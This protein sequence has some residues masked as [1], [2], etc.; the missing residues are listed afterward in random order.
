[1]I[2]AIRP[3]T[4]PAEITL[5]S[6]AADG[7]ANSTA[8]TAIRNVRRPVILPSSSHSFAHYSPQLQ[9]FHGPRQVAPCARGQ[10][11]QQSRGREVTMISRRTFAIGVAL[12]AAGLTRARAQ[13]YPSKP[14]KLIVPFAPG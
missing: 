6:A 4:A 2:C 13:A 1:M 3:R 10:L 14:I 7:V 5:S 9:G 11:V 12:G 8:A